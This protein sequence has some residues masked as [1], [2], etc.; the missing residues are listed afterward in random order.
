M[1]IRHS[2]AVPRR[3]KFRR[4]TK[5]GTE[6]GESGGR[7]AGPRATPPRRRDIEDPALP[8]PPPVALSG[9]EHVS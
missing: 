7:G 8:I 2:V 6:R 4:K 5:S 3:K 9:R 1:R